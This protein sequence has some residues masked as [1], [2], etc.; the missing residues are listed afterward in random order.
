MATDYHERVRDILD[1][2]AAMTPAQ[3]TLFL[4]KTCGRNTALLREVRSLL[5]HYE[6]MDGYQP[7]TPGKSVW[8]LPRATTLTHPATLTRRLT[9]TRR[10]KD[11]A[12]AEPPEPPE[13]PFCLGPYRVKAVLGRGG[14]GVVYRA[15][16]AT[17]RRTVAI[18]VLYRGTLSR[19]ERKRFAMEVEILRNL[20]HPG[21][22]RLIYA[23][24]MGTMRD[25]Q[26]YFVMEHI[27]G[28][29]L[30]RYAETNKLDARQRL[31][32]LVQICAAAEYAHQRGVVHCDLKPEN[33]LMNADGRPK[34][35]D[36]G[37]SRVVAFP[38]PADE[39]AGSF[40]GTP[41]YA[42]PEQ[43]AGRAASLTPRTDVYSLGLI[44]CELLTGRL[45]RAEGGRRRLDLQAIR[46]NAE[47]PRDSAEEKTFRYYLKIILANALARD[48]QERYASAGPFGEDLEGL[49]A[50]C[51][52]P[53]SG[54]TRLK[55][56]A[57]A[58]F[59]PR[60]AWQPT[61]LARPLQAVLRTRISMALQGGRRPTD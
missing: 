13:P 46:L 38:A 15:V 19:E 34:I 27:E 9:K 6:K 37:I 51:A 17:L 11:R 55:R 14:M 33:I 31:E 49:L 30:V 43:W 57:L 52:R 59:A 44:A 40:T 3:R 56:R 21:V 8:K 22:A 58:L 53:A 48:E 61:A 2:A 10:T 20:R 5:P 50:H 26:P 29:S 25:A 18:K 39:E 41:A 35:L 4:R 47:A 23:D 60:A 12:A 7:P 45:P 54:W 1:R 24:L 28:Q 42:S 32:L 36:F 16:H